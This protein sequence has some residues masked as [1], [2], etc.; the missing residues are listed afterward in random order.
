MRPRVMPKL[1]KILRMARMVSG[2][3]P[4]VVGDGD[5][6]AGDMVAVGDMATVVVGTS[7][8]H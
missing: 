5:T 8:N 3:D 2:G 1:A 6:P 7:R 4:V